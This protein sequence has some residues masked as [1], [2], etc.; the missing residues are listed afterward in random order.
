M[1]HLAPITDSSVERCASYEI[2]PVKV[3]L[4]HFPPPELRCS[5]R[6]GALPGLPRHPSEG[7]P[8]SGGEKKAKYTFTGEFYGVSEIFLRPR[9]TTV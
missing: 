5:P 9:K 4:A 6:A 2:S 3:Y 8:S 1:H 7:G